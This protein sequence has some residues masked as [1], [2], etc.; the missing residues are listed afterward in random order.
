MKLDV[1][2]PCEAFALKSASLHLGVCQ[3]QKHEAEALAK[4]LLAVFE[5]REEAKFDLARTPLSGGEREAISN[6][7][8]Q[9]MSMQSKRIGELV[10]KGDWVSLSAF[11]T[12]KQ[13]LLARDGR[14][15]RRVFTSKPTGPSA[16]ELS[17]LAVGMDRPSPLYSARPAGANEQKARQRV[18]KEAGL[19]AVM[20]YQTRA[21]AS[22]YTIFFAFAP[23]S[24]P[25]LKGIYLSLQE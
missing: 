6:F 4:G 23:G 10:A 15:G 5:A 3:E 1:L 8:Q 9:L 22:R 13:I 25:V 7:G 17:V 24:V 16:E 14:E 18:A 21:T 20:W 2:V 19:G 11:L 12:R